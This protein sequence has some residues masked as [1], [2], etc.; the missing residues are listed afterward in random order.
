M[1]KRIVYILILALA[2]AG[3]TS[4][5]ASKS[6]LGDSSNSTPGNGS[7]TQAIPAP[8]SSVETGLKDFDLLAFS[9]L[10]SK[11]TSVETLYSE[12]SG[13]TKLDFTYPHYG[14]NVAVS[15]GWQYQGLEGLLYIQYIEPPQ[16]GNTLYDISFWCF[17]KN[18]D[19]FDQF[20]KDVR[21]ELEQ[22]EFESLIHPNDGEWLP[23]ENGIPQLEELILQP[24]YLKS[25]GINMPYSEL[26]GDYMV[27]DG[28]LLSYPV[29]F[30]G[31][32]DVSVFY[33]GSEVLQSNWEQF[34]N[35]QE[36][37]EEPFITGMGIRIS[38]VAGE[39]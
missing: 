10:F 29:H 15:Y 31:K 32:G 3:C 33:Y 13:I 39:S 20:I 35:A 4:T 19:T 8:S 17:D 22:P 21:A 2:L 26:T 6:D 36:M 5:N 24:I 38:F 27:S 18:R 30:K 34:V 25:S 28:I 11:T 23:Y 7:S 12:I 14:H 16:Q 37:F 1:K 9:T